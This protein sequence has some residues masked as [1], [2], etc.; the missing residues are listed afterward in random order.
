MI[1]GSHMLRLHDGTEVMGTP[2]EM[3]VAAEGRLW[4]E[5]RGDARLPAAV[6]ADARIGKPSFAIWCAEKPM[7]YLQS[8]MQ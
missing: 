8:S 2:V 4:R 1:R 5:V 7:A 6:L 3:E